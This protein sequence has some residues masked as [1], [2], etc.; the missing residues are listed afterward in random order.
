MKG[1]YKIILGISFIVFIT[2]VLF[3]TLS[4]S[5][6]ALTEVRISYVVMIII[7]FF[8]INSGMTD[9][10]KSKG[11]PAKEVEDGSYIVKNFPTI[12]IWY[13]NTKYSE[14]TDIREFD[15][16]N[17]KIGSTKS[18]HMIAQKANGSNRYLEIKAENIPWEFWPL[19]LPG[20]MMEIKNSF[21]TYIYKPGEW[22]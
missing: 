20:H 22:E 13:G 10:K 11:K 21:V 12:E 9:L 16:K 14:Y 15:L 18:V 17:T 6:L 5:E 19:L 1:E 2:L 8:L 7:I 3:K 4:N